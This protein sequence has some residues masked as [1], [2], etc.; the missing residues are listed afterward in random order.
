MKHSIGDKVRFIHLDKLKAIKENGYIGTS[1]L[2]SYSKSEIDREIKR[3]ELALE[4]KVKFGREKY[5][6]KERGPKLSE[7]ER[8]KQKAQGLLCADCGSGYML[9]M[10]KEYKNILRFK[11]EEC[12]IKTIKGEL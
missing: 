7:P 11:C 12:Y 9:Y 5:G 6:P 1:N 2:E 4:Y 3:K 8:W 10:L